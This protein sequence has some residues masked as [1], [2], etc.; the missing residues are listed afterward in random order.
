MNENL[1]PA[2]ELLQAA[3]TVRAE[4]R[5]NICDILSLEPTITQIL[6]E[7]E[8][9][10]VYKRFGPLIKQAAESV[11]KHHVERNI[12]DWPFENF[13]G[14]PNETKHSKLLGYFIDPEKH[15]CWKFLMRKFFDVLSDLGCFPGHTFWVDEHCEV[16]VESGRIDISIKRRPGGSK[17]AVIIENK[18]YDARNQ[19]NQIETYIRRVHDDGFPDFKQIYVLYLPL[20]SNKEP[21]DSDKTFI[22]ENKVNYKKITFETHILEWLNTVLNEKTRSEWPAAMD[23]GM[24]DNISHY[25]NLIYYLINKGKTTNMSREILDKLKQAYDENKFPSRSAVGHLVESANSLKGCHESVLRGKLL[26]QI[27]SLL[28]EIEGVWFCV[29]GNPE[30]IDLNSPFDDRFLGSVDLCIGVG[31]TVSVCFGG[32]GGGYWFGYMRSNKE[33]PNEGDIF[34]EAKEHLENITSDNSYYAYEMTQNVTDEQI[35]QDKSTTGRLV[36]TLVKMRD[37]LADR[38]KNDNNRLIVSQKLAN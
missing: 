16:E 29:D 20:D 30:K 23:V 11:S 3:G 25:R 34:L 21:N 15:D 10:F 13:W 26:L 28:P 8:K 1:S 32:S 17:Y 38:L 27:K 22:D 36:K 6:G 9:D 2:I 31:D 24:R 37:S 7:E 12:T 18:I 33:D 35:D 4:E 5:R 14:Q 19:P